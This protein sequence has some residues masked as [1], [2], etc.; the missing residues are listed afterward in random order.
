MVLYTDYI[1]NSHYDALWEGQGRKFDTKEQHLRPCPSHNASFS[2]LAI[3]F[4]SLYNYL[5]S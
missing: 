5:S 1:A 2:G 3:G 4:I